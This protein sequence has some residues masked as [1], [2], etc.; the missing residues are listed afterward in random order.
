MSILRGTDIEYAAALLKAGKR[1]AIPTETVYGLAANGTNP[2]AVAGIFAAKQRPRFD[3][4]ILHF[5]SVEDATP[6]VQH[7]PENWLALV[8]KLSPG[9]VTYVVERTASVPDLVSSGLPTVGIRFPQHP[10]TCELLS[11]L[12]FPLAAPSANKFG[13]ISPTHPDH[14][15]LQ[16]TNE[17]DYILDGGA[18]TLGLESTILDL[19]KPVISVLRKGSLPIEALIEVLG[20]MPEIAE[21]SSSRPSA[22][23]NI[24]VHYA[25]RTPLYVQSFASL[26]AGENSGVMAFGNNASYLKSIHCIQL[27]ASSDDR[28]AAA[29]FFA[30]LHTLDSDPRVEIIYCEPFP[31]RGLGRALNDRLKR[32]AVRF[33]KH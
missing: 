32:A 22:P 6:Y 5:A 21:V 19:T 13:Y 8:S 4:L 29:R 25:P 24:D 27:S 7:L 11:L 10:L 18:C 3:P 9:P 12:P 1:V 23:G 28:E 20:Y 30:A 14:I 31:D 15:Q 26:N 33:I 16:F 17:I 2:Q